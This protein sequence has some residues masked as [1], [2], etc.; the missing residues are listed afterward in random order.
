MEHF[1][2]EKSNFED[3]SLIN[4]ESVKLIAEDRSP[5]IGVMWSRFLVRDIRR[6]AMV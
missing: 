1:V 4:W 2:G 5:G 3:D 6:A